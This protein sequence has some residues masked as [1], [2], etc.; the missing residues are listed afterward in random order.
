MAVNLNPETREIPLVFKD[1]TLIFILRDCTTEEMFQHLNML[2]EKDQGKK[3]DTV[4]QGFRIELI[5]KLLLDVK[6]L[7]E[8]G[9]HEDVVYTDPA[10]KEEKPLTP[11]VSDWKKHIKDLYKLLAAGELEQNYFNI[12]TARLKN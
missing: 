6:V 5:D 2:S 10:T 12:E 8:S 11:A 3:V 9:E 7:A 1:Y 4:Q